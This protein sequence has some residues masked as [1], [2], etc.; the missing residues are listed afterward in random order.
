VS[1]VVVKTAC[2][3]PIAVGAKLTL[4]EHVEPA[5]EFGDRNARGQHVIGAMKSLALAPVITASVTFKGKRPM[6]VTRMVLGPTVC[7]ILMLPKS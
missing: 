7:P 3:G 6:F 2:R 5:P 1:V 4:T